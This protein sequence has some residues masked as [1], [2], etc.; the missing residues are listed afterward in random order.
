MKRRKS[1]KSG[2]APSLFALDIGTRSVV[3]MLG[4]LHERRLVID[5]T[6]MIFHESRAMFDGQ[7]H[8][9]DK[10]AQVIKQVKQQLEKRSKQ[11][12]SEVTIAAAGRALQTVTLEWETQL[13]ELQAVTQAQVHQLELEALQQAQYMLQEDLQED[14]RYFC[15][16]HSV[17]HYAIDGAV[18]TN[19]TGHHGRRIKVHLIATF[20][21]KM[22][23]DSLYTAVSKAGLE[24]VYMTLEPIAA[25]EVAVPENARLLNIAL[26]DVGAGTS[27]M[28]ITR[29]G[30]IIAYG[31]SAVAGDEIT[32]LL[33]KEEM[34]DFDGAEQLKCRLNMEESHYYT[35]IF[36]FQQEKSTPE[37]LK[38]IQPAIQVVA[39]EIAAGIL[40][41]NGKKPSAVFLIGGG[42]QIPGLPQ[43]LGQQLELPPERVAVRH[44]GQI[45]DLEYNASLDL[46]PE[47]VT[48][49]GI[50]KKAL[51][52]RQKD[53]FEVEVN[54]RQ[55]RMFQTR[56]LCIKDA[57]AAVQYDP[58]QL[59]PRRGEGIDVTVNGQSMRLYGEYGEAAVIF[60]NGQAAN[61]ESEIHQGDKILIQPATS[62]KKRRAL[63]KEVVPS[64][65]ICQVEGIKR[66]LIV[67][68]TLNGQQV[69]RSDILLNQGDAIGY[70]TLYTVEDCCQ[71]YQLTGNAS[72]FR[73][74]GMPATG[75]TSLQAGDALENVNRSSDTISANAFEAKPVKAADPL[76]NERNIE[77]I[78]PSAASSLENPKV[79]MEA[80][81]M[82]FNIQYNGAP[83]TIE[84]EKKT[85]VFIDLFDYVDFDRSDVQGKL[86]L[87]HN[88]RPAEYTAVINSGD[89]IWV[90]WDQE[91]YAASSG[92][93]GSKN[94]AGKLTK[95]NH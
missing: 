24:V 79:T 43:A 51:V 21:P 61:L 78:E 53:F 38:Q 28:A 47:G 5:H 67:N 13:D 27:D 91:T 76:H 29:D 95:N 48:P 94:D 74:N 2:Q 93:K 12:L 4:H 65:M 10:V 80:D 37:L 20:L 45:A 59:V 87:T 88:G 82:R 72:D 3:G 56:R 8:D 19:P 54:G 92:K 16:G 44:I 64:E 89:D 77:K 34:L 62:G 81:I 50:L 69:E 73:V 57:L 9:I 83:L 26:V 1:K 31:M 17:I 40:E 66:S 68:M 35:D 42:S 7:I 30:T 39:G 15:V 23:V 71:F 18:V 70:D 86:V 60:L 90:Y 55:V 36:G 41:K 25:I 33:A 52:A 32:E 75:R 49:I 46:G 85:L 14:T 11:T 58:Q 22:V 6:A 63:I 84:T